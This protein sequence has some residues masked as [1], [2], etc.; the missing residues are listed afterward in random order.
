M[1]DNSDPRQGYIAQYSKLEQERINEF[2]SVVPPHL[3]G[4]EQSEAVLEW[5]WNTFAAVA[6]DQ[7]SFE[8]WRK[9]IS[10][11]SRSLLRYCAASQKDLALHEVLLSGWGM[12]I[13]ELFDLEA[14]AS[15]CTKINRWSFF[16]TSEVCNVPGGVARLVR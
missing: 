7:P 6:G 15:Y 4:V 16:M 1:N 12:P 13:G 10:F 9:S 5:I 3:S 8:C 14:L 2:A 11:H